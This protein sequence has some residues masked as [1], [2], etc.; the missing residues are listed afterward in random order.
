LLSALSLDPQER[1][2]FLALADFYLKSGQVKKAKTLAD[3]MIRKFPD[4]GAAREL[5]NYLE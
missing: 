5:L 1:D 3:D 4:Y 2:F